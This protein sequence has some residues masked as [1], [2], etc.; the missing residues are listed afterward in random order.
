MLSKELGV[1]DAIV[2]GAQKGKLSSVCESFTHGHAYLYYQSVR[3]EYS[4]TDM[5]IDHSFDL[6][7]NDLTRLYRAHAMAEIVL[8]MHGGD[9]QMLYDLLEASLAFLD[10]EKFDS[11]LVLLQFMWRSISIMG[12]E[13][14]LHSCPIC[15]KQFKENEVLSF[16]DSMH[17]VCCNSCAPQ[18]PE[19]SNLYLRPG[20]RRYFIYTTELTPIDAIQVELS[21]NAKRRILYYLIDY[22]NNI[23]GYSLKSLQN[24]FLMI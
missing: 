8:R 21:D 3:K 17:T 15:Q 6:L 5:A 2:Y 1:F 22:M 4:V 23:L 19:F 10:E 20:M 12:L 13:P 16:H 7:R 11:L 24:S 18:L 14:D 9:F